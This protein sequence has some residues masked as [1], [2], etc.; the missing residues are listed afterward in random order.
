MSNEAMKKSLKEY[1]KGMRVQ[2]PFMEGREKGDM[3]DLVGVVSTIRD[4]GFLTDKKGKTYACFI[5]DERKDLFYFGGQVLTDDLNKFEKDGFHAAIQ[6]DGLPVLFTMKRG[7]D[8]NR[9]YAEPTYYP[10]E[11]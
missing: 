9:D 3:K 4:Y 1:A 2:I 5:V 11:D 8:S 6:E 7:Q 10:D